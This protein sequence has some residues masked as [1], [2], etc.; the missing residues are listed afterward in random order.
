MIAPTTSPPSAMNPVS[1][2]P[3]S[4]SRPAPPNSA[5]Q[6][7]G[8]GSPTDT[9]LA[10]LPPSSQLS[11]GA[12]AGISIGVSFV[13]LSIFVA[14]GWYIRRLRRELTVIQQAAAGVP[15]EVWKA[16]MATVAAP[17]NVSRANSGSGRGR[18]ISRRFSRDSPV[19]PLSPS[20]MGE[21]ETVTDNGYGILTRKRGHVLSVVIEGENEDSTSIHRYVHEP[22]PGQREGLTSP[23]EM[24]GEGAMIWEM[25]IAITPR[26][27]SVER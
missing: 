10:L 22:V 1:T 11:E 4:T 3:Q 16:S 8:N 9:P 13:A 14:L 27:R 6:S 19:S 12:K 26:N 25:P 5:T 24:D 20:G 15:N 23:L 21:V 7:P 2:D 17:V 18:R